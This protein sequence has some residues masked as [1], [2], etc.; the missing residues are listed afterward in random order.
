MQLEGVRRKGVKRRRE[1]ARRAGTCERL[2]G[3]SRRERRRE[4]GPPAGFPAYLFAFL[5]SSPPSCSLSKLCGN[6]LPKIPR[7]IGKLTNLKE[8]QVNLGFFFLEFAKS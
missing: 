6:N 1:E 7:D 4:E 2:V 3:G 5:F 8:L